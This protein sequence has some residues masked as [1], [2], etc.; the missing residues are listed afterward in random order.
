MA[1]MCT[2]V[3]DQDAKRLKSLIDIAE[4]NGGKYECPDEETFHF[5]L[6]KGGTI[7]GI[8]NQFHAEAGRYKTTCVFTDAA[9]GKTVRFC[10]YTAQPVEW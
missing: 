5:I 7:G 1:S 9:A 10:V 4:R 2:A 3:K 8:R 6:K